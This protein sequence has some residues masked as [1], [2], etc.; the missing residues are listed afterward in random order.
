[1]R[2]FCRYGP[3]KAYLYSH[4]L[5]E[6]DRAEVHGRSYSGTWLW[7][8][9]DGLDRHCWSAAS[10]LEV[11]GDTSTLKF[12]V[13]RLPHATLYGPPENVRAERDGNQVIVAWEKVWMTEDDNRGYLIE[14]NICQNGV[15]IFVAVQ[16]YDNYYEFVDEAGCGMP[17]NGKLYTVEKHGYTDP[18]EIPWP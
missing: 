15:L 8:K 14:A 2:A 13:S 18:V 4:E 3:G 6:G 17:S 1:M 9:P 7:L 16:T 10:V 12:V 11:S 5:K